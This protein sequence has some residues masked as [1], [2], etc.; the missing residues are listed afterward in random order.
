ME[1]D[2]LLEAAQFTGCQRIG[3]SNDRNDV[4][5]GRKAP[6]ELNVHFPQTAKRGCQSQVKAHKRELPTRDQWE[7]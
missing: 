2:P 5:A 7:G 6:H 3:L 1:T 4:D